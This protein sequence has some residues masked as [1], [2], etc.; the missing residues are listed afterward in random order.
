MPTPNQIHVVPPEVTVTAD[1]LLR[2]PQ[3][4]ITLKG[5][6]GNV[7]VILEYSKAWLAGVGCIPLHSRMEDAATVISKRKAKQN[8][9]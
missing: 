9:N 8:L 3:G 2:I 6:R 4:P 7:N 1:D 5:L